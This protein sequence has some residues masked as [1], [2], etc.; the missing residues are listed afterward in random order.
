[1]SFDAGADLDRCNAL[2]VFHVGSGDV[3]GVDV[4]GVTVA[5]VIDA[6]KVMTDGGWRLGVLVDERATAE[7]ADKLLEVFGGQRGGPMEALG[8][9]V[10]EQLGV[11]RLPMEVSEGDGCHVLRVGDSIDMQVEDLV[12]FGV[13]DGAPAKLDGVFH[14]AGST[15]T[16]ARTTRARWK[17]FGIDVEHGPRTSGFAAPFAWS[18]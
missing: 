6:P 5:A 10:G 8:P 2:L 14:P 1:M 16:I 11:E 15:L 12:P 17:A 18:G 13:E 3:D 9:L 4:A 7:Q